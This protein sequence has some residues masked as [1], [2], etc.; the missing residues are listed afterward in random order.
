MLISLTTVWQFCVKFWAFWE[1]DIFSQRI[2]QISEE[3]MKYRRFDGYRRFDFM[4]RWIPNSPLPTGNCPVVFPTHFNPNSLLISL[5]ILLLFMCTP[6]LS[7]IS[8]GTLET[9]TIPHLFQPLFVCAMQWPV[10][11]SHCSLHKLKT[12]VS[13]ESL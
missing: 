12:L 1:R 8:F 6:A 13:K 4:D 10:I 5:Q 9:H 3:N 7:S 11:F 2:G